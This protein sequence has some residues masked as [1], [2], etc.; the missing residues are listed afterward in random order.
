[1]EN[2]KENINTSQDR[3]ESLAKE[4]F[5]VQVECSGNEQLSDVKKKLAKTRKLS[6]SSSGV[7]QKEII[8]NDKVFVSDNGQSVGSIIKTMAVNLR[9]SYHQLDVNKKAVVSLGLNSIIDLSFQYPGAQAPLFSHKQWLQLQKKYKPKNYN[10]S[11]YSDIIT[12]LKPIFASFNRKKNFDQ[13]WKTIYTKAK[14]LAAQHDPELD[15]DEADVSFCIHFILQI[16]TAIKH[17]PSLFN[18]TVNNSEWDYIVKFWG[19]VIERL[20]F[21]TGLRLKWGDTHLTLIDTVKDMSLKV[22]LRILH[23]GIKQRYNIENEVGVVEVAEED[24]GDAK[25]NGDRCKVLIENK[26][27]IDRYLLDGCF[28][29]S[30]D[31]LQICGLEIFLINLTLEDQGLYVG[32]QFYHSVVNNSLDSLEKYMELAFTLLCFRDNC[33]EINNKYE[34]HIISL[35]TQKKSAKRPASQIMDDGLTTKQTWIRGSWNP[36]RTTKSQPPPEPSK[37]CFEG[38]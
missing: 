1:M 37:L 16:L 4:Y 7:E 35:R 14:E 27:I 3:V 33:V 9:Q 12:I 38:S 10:T 31:S 21:F 29:D 36:P 28:V 2:D 6:Q 18:D 32:T 22:D 23:D 26:A 20:F 25:F 15:T 24:P 34:S 11:I 5:F 13:N 19:V 8:E 17:Q 30:V